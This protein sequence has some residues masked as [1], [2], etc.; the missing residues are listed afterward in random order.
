MPEDNNHYCQQDENLKSFTEGCQYGNVNVS[1]T[2]HTVGVNDP[3]LNLWKIL[4][5]ITNY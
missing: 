3:H 5:W 4:Q 2:P 1:Y